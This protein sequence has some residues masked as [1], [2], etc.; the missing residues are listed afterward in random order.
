MIVISDYQKLYSYPII[1]VLT[2]LLL[3]EFADATRMPYL[4]TW[5]V[6]RIRSGV[7]GLRESPRPRGI[8]PLQS[9]DGDTHFWGKNRHLI[10][11]EVL[12]HFVNS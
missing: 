4:C 10:S 1:Q 7:I 3:L 5:K 8:T 12:F 11:Y 6:R 9:K 2:E